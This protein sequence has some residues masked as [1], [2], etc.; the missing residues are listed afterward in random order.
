MEDAL[1]PETEL[2][3][4]AGVPRLRVQSKQPDGLP[5]TWLERA[6]I[7]HPQ[8]GSAEQHVIRSL[9]MA[10]VEAEDETPRS[11]VISVLYEFLEDRKAALVSI[12]Q[13]DRDLVDVVGAESCHFALI[14]LAL[15]AGELIN[16][17]GAPGRAPYPSLRS[18]TARQFSTAA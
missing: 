15:E 8:G 7:Q 5:I 14:L 12:A 2:P 11:R 6:V 18:T 4:C 3:N 16:L 17:L 10:R 13:I 9:A 1:H